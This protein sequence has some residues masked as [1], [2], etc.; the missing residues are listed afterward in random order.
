[1]QMLW[2]SV[3]KIKSNKYK[4]KQSGWRSLLLNNKTK[5]KVHKNDKMSQPHPGEKGF[6]KLP[7]VFI[8]CK[9]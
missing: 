9:N 7:F 2:L 4:M 3:T 1:M 5:W 8:G 6:F